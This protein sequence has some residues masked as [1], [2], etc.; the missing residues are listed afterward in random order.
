MLV[1][2]TT[3]HLP[4][5]DRAGVDADPHGEWH[6]VGSLQTGIQG[7]DGLD[8]AQAGVHGAPSVVFMRRGVAKID[9]QPVAEVLR[10]VAFVTLDDRGRGFLVGADHRAQVFGVKLAGELRGAHQVTEQHRE[11]AAFGLR[12]PRVHRSEGHLNGQL[13]WDVKRS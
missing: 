8:H 3:P 10:D 12:R 1:P 5:H 11:L 2:L 4:H 9:Q 6:P 7:G 13:S